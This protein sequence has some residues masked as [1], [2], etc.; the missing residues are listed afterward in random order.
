MHLNLNSRV[1]SAS[2]YYK[3]VVSESA[4]FLRQE[5]NQEASPMED[6]SESRQNGRVAI[7][8]EE[9][10]LQVVR[11]AYADGSSFLCLRCKGVVKASRM[12]EHMTIWCPGLPGTSEP[13]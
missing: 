4:K 8:A 13:G 2:A 3:E 12:D 10:R 11:D 1:S 7:L 6:D 5:S 9:G